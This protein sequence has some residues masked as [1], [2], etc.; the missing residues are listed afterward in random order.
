MQLRLYIT[1]CYSWYVCIKLINPRVI[2]S[3]LEY[4]IHWIASITRERRSWEKPSLVNKWFFLLNTCL[5]NS[6]TKVWI[7][8]LRIWRD[9]ISPILVNF[10]NKYLEQTI[11]FTKWEPLPVH[12]S[13]RMNFNFV[14]T[15]TRFDYF[16]FLSIYRLFLLRFNVSFSTLL[17][18]VRLSLSKTYKCYMHFINITYAITLSNTKLIHFF[19]YY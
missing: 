16:C 6:I 13:I 14:S 12:E 4:W 15:L 3:I 11:D 10:W 8:S 18:E 19:F 17:L 2:T 5:N 1:F 7:W 9:R